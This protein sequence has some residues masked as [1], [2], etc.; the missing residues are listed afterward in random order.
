MD[1]MSFS[2]TFGDTYDSSEAQALLV[3]FA[4]N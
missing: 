2:G 3:L 1:N 4:T